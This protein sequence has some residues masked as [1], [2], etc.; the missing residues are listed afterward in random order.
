MP[1]M[2]LNPPLEDMGD[3]PWK[4]EV[5]DTVK[6]PNLHLPLLSTGLR[7]KS[8]VM[9]KSLPSHFSASYHL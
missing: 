1:R 9:E 2:G 5:A 4:V 6:I 8:R 3:L 7:H